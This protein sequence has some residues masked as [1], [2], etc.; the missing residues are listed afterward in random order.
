MHKVCSTLHRFHL[1]VPL[2]LRVV[3]GGLFVWHG[4]DKF[5]AGIDMVEQMF[6]MWGV[7]APGLTAPLTAIVEIAAG[8]MLLLGVATRVAAMLLSVVMIGA[9]LYVKADL[10][11]ISSEPM[12]GAELDLSMLAGL[13]ALIVLGPG[14]LSVDHKLG[15]EPAG[16]SM[17]EQGA[18]TSKSPALAGR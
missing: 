6:T 11:V 9:L 5:D 12:P 10:G 1:V 18:G 7:P 17:P 3:L 2:V 14:P 8:A 16:V 13:V 4:V 15:I